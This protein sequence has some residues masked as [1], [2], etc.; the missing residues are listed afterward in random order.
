MK[1]IVRLLFV[2]LLVAPEAMRAAPTSKVQSVNPFKRDNIVITQPRPEVSSSDDDFVP[3]SELVEPAR[4][5]PRRDATPDVHNQSP[6][7]RRKATSD[8]QGAPKQKVS[9]KER[10]PGVRFE[11]PAAA[12][13]EQDDV[14]LIKRRIGGPIEGGDVPDEYIT[15]SAAV[16]P[17]D[18]D[19]PELDAPIK[20]APPLVR[21]GAQ[22]NLVPQAISSEPTVAQVRAAL[23]LYM[24]TYISPQQQQV[25]LNDLA[26]QK[27]QMEKRKQVVENAMERQLKNSKL[28][29]TEQEIR[30]QHELELVNINKTLQL[31]DLQ[32][33]ALQGELTQEERERYV[34]AGQTIETPKLQVSKGILSKI[35]EAIKN[36]FKADKTRGTPQQEGVEA[37]KLALKN[38]SRK[39]RPAAYET[40]KSL[41]EMH[42]KGILDLDENK[43]A[44][45]KYIVKKTE[46]L[47]VKVKRLINRKPLIEGE[48]PAGQEIGRK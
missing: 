43:Y 34:V 35:G 1:I 15:K 14:P 28:F 45:Q 16:L 32:Q 48:V 47:K 30:S 39:A 2:V 27:Q 23:A 11:R 22:V 24:T 25:Y 42:N 41:L 40:S 18:L 37:A 36:L 5:K 3:P 29:G 8:V 44:E 7:K 46:P 31:I 21:Q 20:A 19:E 38:I 13:D 12:Q 4:E 26:D 10:R 17:P 33:R 9:K 6:K